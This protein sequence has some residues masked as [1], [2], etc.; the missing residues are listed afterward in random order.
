MP[1]FEDYVE[2]QITKMLYLGHT[3]AGKTGSVVSLAAAGYNV[4]IADLDKGVEV[5]KDFVMNS[6]SPYRKAHKDGLWTKEQ[7]DTLSSRIRY[8]PISDSVS[9]GSKGELLTRGDSWAKFISLMQDWKDGDKSYGAISS[10]GPKDIL[11][12]DGLS[13]LADAAFNQHLAMNSRLG[14]PEQRDYGAAQGALKRLLWM[15][16]SDE[17]KCNI[18][19]VCHIKP[20]DI[21]GEP[22]RGFPQTIGSA[23]SPEIGQFFN[24]A[25][26]ARQSGQGEGIKRVISTRTSGFVQL[27]T[28]APLRVKPE[29]PLEDGLAAYFAD[30]R[31]K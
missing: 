10:W 8:V 25:L 26:L 9:V 17:I 29:Y 6:A 28:P 14:K 16:Y 1:G 11:F 21:E 3:G 19:M 30:I 12:I 18:I 22:T 20:V 13:R 27:K 31:R 4:Y 24:H 23:L 5:I 7:A 15:L 2:S